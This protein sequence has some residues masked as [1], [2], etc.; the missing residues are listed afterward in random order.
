MFGG[1]AA[2][3]VIALV[4]RL[5]GLFMFCLRPRC[6]SFRVRGE[7]LWLVDSKF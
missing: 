7:S 1:E 6:G 3:V 2:P 5:R 4:F